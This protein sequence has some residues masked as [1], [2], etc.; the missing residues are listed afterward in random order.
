VLYRGEVWRGEIAFPGR[1][2]KL[3]RV[4]VLQG[5]PDFATEP[6]VGIVVASTDHGRRPG[7]QHEVFVP[8]EPGRFQLDTVIDCR[9]VYTVSRADVEAMQRLFRLQTHVMEWVDEALV[10]GL[11]MTGIPQN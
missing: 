7:E 5:G 1:P 8:A 2:A 6:D 3:K 10:V 4:V 11:Q 9:W